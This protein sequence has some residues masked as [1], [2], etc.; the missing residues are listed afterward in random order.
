MASFTDSSP[1]PGAA[2]DYSAVVDWGD[3]SS[4][5]TGGITDNGGGNYDV[6]ASPTYA[7]AGE[8]QAT[9]TITDNRDPSRTATAYT[10]IDVY[11]HR[12]GHPPASHGQTAA[13]APMGA[14]DLGSSRS[15]KSPQPDNDL[16]ALATLPGAEPNFLL[17]FPLANTSRAAATAG[18]TM[19][20]PPLPT[21][22]LEAWWTQDNRPPAP[23]A[24]WAAVAVGRAVVPDLLVPESL[25]GLSVNLTL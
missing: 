12:R 5:S 7:A 22:A 4:L 25:D 13:V 16:A 9:I 1:N 11:D 21:S 18:H 14:L 17:H 19:T 20:H 15:G 8:Y 24:A 6:A 23:H 2:T 3:G 10:T